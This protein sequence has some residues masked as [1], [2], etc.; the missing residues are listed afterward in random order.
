M[1]TIT[2]F[3][4]LIYWSIIIFGPVVANDLKHN[5]DIKIVKNLKFNK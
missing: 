4:L 5:K 2:V 3:I 1:K